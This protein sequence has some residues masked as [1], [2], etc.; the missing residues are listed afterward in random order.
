MGHRDRFP[1]KDNR[2]GDAEERGTGEQNLSASG[3][4]TLGR[5]N[6]QDDT[7]AVGERANRK[8]HCHCLRIR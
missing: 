2:K 1:E 5:T 7:R 8:C 3:T 4:D 6:V